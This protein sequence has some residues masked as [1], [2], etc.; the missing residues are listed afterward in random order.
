VTL[1]LGGVASTAVQQL[2]LT[3]EASMKA[4]GW[5]AAA[6]AAIGLAAGVVSA[7]PGDEPAKPAPAAKATPAKV[8][9]PKPDK[10]RATKPGRPRMIHRL[11]LR[12]T[13]AG[14][15]TWSPDGKLLA[16]RTA[17]KFI[18]VF[19]ATTLKPRALVQTNK[20]HAIGFF[21][22]QPVLVTDRREAGQIN[23]E[24]KLEFWKVPE[25][26]KNRPTLST[27]T[28]VTQLDPDDGEPFALLPDDKSVLCVAYRAA[29][30]HSGKGV[31]YNAMFRIVDVGTGRLVREVLQFQYSGTLTHCVSPDGKSLYLGSFGNGVG[32]LECRAISTGKQVWEREISKFTDAEWEQV[33]EPFRRA[34][35]SVIASPDGKLIAASFP[36]KPFQRGPNS[37]LPSELCLFDAAT[38]APGVRPEGQPARFINGE[39]FSSDSRMMSGKMFGGRLGPK[40]VIW[41]T[42]S[43]KILKSWL[44]NASAQFSPTRPVATILEYVDDSEGNRQFKTSI[45]GLWDVAPLL[46][47]APAK[48]PTPPGG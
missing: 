3:G 27:P 35:I 30:D 19:D 39:S 40:L 16:L 17:E 23:G 9:E 14:E 22:D 5:T 37:S 26:G 42:K 33:R 10:E 8:E 2:T 21:R 46:K 29:L 31:Q 20:P 36:R 32:R 11:E 45:L 7:L 28:D 18:T 25:L 38:G 24:S 4:I 44:G 34:Q 13:T 41:D 1:A 43:G 47:A 6:C 48:S 15:P 12:D